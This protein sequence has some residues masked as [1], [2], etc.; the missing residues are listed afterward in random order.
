[1]AAETGTITG[2][3]RAAM[4]AFSASSIPNRGSQGSSAWAMCDMVA[5]TPGATLA[6][7]WKEMRGMLLGSLWF[8]MNSFRFTYV[9][10]SNARISP[11]TSIQAYNWLPK[12]ILISQVVNNVMVQKLST[13]KSQE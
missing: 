10:S 3:L 8:L 12:H 6:S 5:M 2:T 1:M 13:A 11:L 9:R 4:A 7:E